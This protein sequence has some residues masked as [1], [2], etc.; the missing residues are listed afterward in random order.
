MSTGLGEA[1]CAEPL[2]IG[3][4]VHEA[5]EVDAHLVAARR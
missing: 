4:L 1:L 2:L 3:A 5:G